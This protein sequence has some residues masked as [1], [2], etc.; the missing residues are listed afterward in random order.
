M[1]EPINLA[2]VRVHAISVPMRPDP[3][4]LHKFDEMMLQANGDDT[5]QADLFGT[6]PQGKPY[7]ESRTFNEQE[8]EQLRKYFMTRE[9]A[10]LPPFSS[11]KSGNTIGRV[12]GETVPATVPASQANPP[13]KAETDA[14]KGW[15]GSASPWVHGG[16]DALGFMPGLGAIPDLINVG[17]YA[18]EGDAVNA[19]LSAVAAIPFAGDAIKGGVLVGKGA[20][21]LGAEVAQQTAHKAAKEA[22]ERAEREA[23]ERLWKNAVE[24]P[25]AGQSATSK[26]EGGGKI[27]Q[28]TTFDVECFNLPEGANEDEFIRQLK[29]QEDA[30]N[31]M[32][33]DT[34]ISRRKA[35]DDAGGTE[36]LRDKKAQRK[37]RKNYERKRLSDLLAQDV[38]ANK[39]KKIVSTELKELAATHILDIIAGGNPSDVT[40]GDKR[41]NSSV[42]A[43]WK[44]RRSQSIENHAKEMAKA[45]TGKEKM[46]VKLKRC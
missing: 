1:A 38:D 23:S 34:L 37:A 16:L 39:A 15:W 7:H 19:G 11:F 2:P 21:H 35:I 22:T 9:L 30:L 27:K 18:A 42:G 45:G 43:Q 36:A 41:T 40:M 46:K 6:D 20:H 28:R 26:A 13:I 25:M 8:Y 24:H 3:T 44:G 4:Q 32:D 5:V 31:A 17:I 14:E 10:T 12:V 29:E 33:A